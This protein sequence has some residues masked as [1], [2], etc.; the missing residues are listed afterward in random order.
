VNAGDTTA[1]RASS[2]RRCELDLQHVASAPELFATLLPVS[3]NES[4]LSTAALT[5]RSCTE[6]QTDEQK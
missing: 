3:S 1:K 5:R 2:A 4:I 6:D